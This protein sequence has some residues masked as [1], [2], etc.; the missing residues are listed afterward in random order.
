MRS[1]TFRFAVG[2]ILLAFVVAS[3]EGGIF[4]RRWARCGPSSSCGT[5]SA[6]NVRVMP[7]TSP[8]S[9]PCDNGLCPIDRQ[10]GWIKPA[11]QVEQLTGVDRSTGVGKTDSVCV[12][13]KCMPRFLA[14]Q[15]LQLPLPEDAGKPYVVIVGDGKY[16]ADAR[17]VV[18][19]HKL[20]EVYHVVGYA[21]GEWQAAGVGYG[22]GVWI[23]TGRDAGGKAKVISLDENLM[24]LDDA[25]KTSAEALRRPDG[26][27]D[28]LKVP[29]LKKALDPGEIIKEKAKTYV[30]LAIGGASLLLLGI[31]AARKGG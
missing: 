15:E 21:E 24:V 19:R 8:S 25:L 7:T 3:V 6:C 2:A 16:Q 10:G 1:F 5:I 31:A 14:N 23:V 27:L 29:N 26:I 17:A 22:K 9:A 12:G 13:G 28:R 20:H 30:P 11:G 4:F 18:E